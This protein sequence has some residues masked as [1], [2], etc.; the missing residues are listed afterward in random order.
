MTS[1]N[2]VNAPQ[3]VPMKW[4]LTLGG[5]G[6]TD[7]KSFFNFT[8]YKADCTSWKRLDDK[9]AVA[10]RHETNQNRGR[11]SWLL[12]PEEDRLIVELVYGKS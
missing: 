5:V 11:A 9:D 7:P 4:T 6:V 10:E 8:S 3:A 2:S 1:V 12:S